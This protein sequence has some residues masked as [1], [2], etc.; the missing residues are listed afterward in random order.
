MN[1]TMNN[2]FVGDEIIF[3][4]TKIQSNHDLYWKVIRKKNNEVMI[5]LKDMGFDENWPPVPGS[6]FYEDQ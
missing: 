2:V 6:A 4:S 5:E 3:N 1:Y